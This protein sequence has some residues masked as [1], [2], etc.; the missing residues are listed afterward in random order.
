MDVFNLLSFIGGLAFFLYGMNVMGSGLEKVA[1]GRLERLLE[2]L[3]AGTLRGVISG[4]AVTAVIQSSTATTVMVIGFVNSG[5]MKLENAVGIIMGANL[6]TTVTSWM[7]SLSGLGGENVF[8][9][10]LEPSSL[11]PMAAMIGLVLYKTLKKDRARTAGEILLGF[12][13]LMT[14]MTMMSGA[15]APLAE[16][17][18]FVG[19]LS[20]FGN[21]LLGIL[22]GA[23]VTAIV[24]SSSASM[25][26]LQA[27]S[28][29]GAVSFGTALP[30]VVGQNI[31]TCVTAL[32]A[33]VGAGKN[34][35]RAAFVHL[36]FNIIGSAIVLI[37]S[38]LVTLT[39]MP[40]LPDLRATPVAIAVLHTAFNLM[41]TLALLPF[42]RVL[43]W[44]S[45]I[46]VRGGRGE[47]DSA[48]DELL[49]DAR[50]LAK[51]SFALR[52]SE[53]AVGRMVSRTFDAATEACMMLDAP[54]EERLHAVADTGKSLYAYGEKLRAYTLKI[55]SH[56]LSARESEDLAGS[57]YVIGELCSIADASGEL[58]GSLLRLAEPKDGLS[59]EAREELGDEISRLC[60]LACLT[61]GVLKGRRQSSCADIAEVCERVSSA[62]V[63]MKEGHVERLRAGRCKPESSPEFI[64]ALGACTRMAGN[65]MELARLAEK[66]RK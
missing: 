55:N 37:V 45:R 50:A 10:L 4:A 41:A 5:I 52:L 63:D 18:E 42:S 65:C 58:A 1:G 28:A 7:L 64:G 46:T 11:A 12:A 60:R 19:L 6:G 47:Q 34:A 33:S 51:P 25:G 44:L 62:C 24:Q 30:I 40:G 56:E 36:Y 3:S 23:A 2:R 26:I 20:A 13:L 53:I 32:I 15:V 14:G 66:K 27:L 17:P 49:M 35:K 31:G 29:T 59:D 61:H 21:P 43:E 9:R 39:L 38:M 57:L 16:V 8:V 48:S 22:A 54:S